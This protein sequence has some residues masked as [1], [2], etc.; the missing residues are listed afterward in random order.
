MHNDWVMVTVNVS[1]DPVE[2]LEELADGGLEVLGEGRTD[3][4]G[5]HGFVVNV[6][7]YPCHEVFDV[8]GRGHL[9]RFGVAGRGV[10]PEVFES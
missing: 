3:A 9:G 1:V 8:F 5:E 10:L 4:R 2:A 6:R 7:L